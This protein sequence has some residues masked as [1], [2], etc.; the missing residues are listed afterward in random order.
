MAGPRRIPFIEGTWK[1]RTRLFRPDRFLVKLEDGVQ[2]SAVPELLGV[3]L[4]SVGGKHIPFRSKHVAVIQLQPDAEVL[5]RIDALKGNQALADDIEWAEPDFRVRS[6][7]GAA[8]MPNDPL[9]TDPGDGS[10]WQWG[11]EPM[12]MAEA[13]ARQRGSGSVI[14]VIVDNGFETGHPDLTSGRFLFG[15][16]FL[17]IENATGTFTPDGIF[18]EVMPADMQDLQGHGVGMAGVIAADCDNGTTVAGVNWA[19]PIG[20]CCSM[21]DGD[22]YE[23]GVAGSTST[24][25]A[26]VLQAIAYAKV[27]GLHLVV[28]L[29]LEFTDDQLSAKFASLEI[30]TFRYMCEQA[31]D[32]GALLVCAGGNNGKTALVSPAAYASEAEFQGTVLAVGFTCLPDHDPGKPV[33]PSGEYVSSRSHQG[34]TVVA[35]GY[36]WPLLRLGGADPQADWG[37]SISAAHVSGLASLIWSHR[38]DLAA[39]DVIE[40]IKDT[41]ELP[42]DP[43]VLL[44]GA[45]RINAY[46]ALRA[47]EKRPVISLV[48]DTSGSMAGSSGTPGV[49]RMQVLQGAADILLHVTEGDSHV[50]IVQFSSDAV[51]VVAAT[52]IDPTNPAATQDT[53]SARVA[54]L[55][56][57]GATSI[58]A[59]V[60]AGVAQAQG[61]AEASVTGEASRAVILM[62]DGR[63]NAGPRVHPGPGDSAVDLAAL[64]ATGIPVYSVGTG[65][66]SAVDVDA[67]KTLAEETGG[68]Y[69][70]TGPWN[71]DSEQTMAKFFCQVLAETAGYAS[72]LDPSGVL[73]KAGGEEVV[74][75]G[76]TRDEQRIEVILMKPA[77]VPMRLTLEAPDGQEIDASSAVP[78]GGVEYRVS[79]RVIVMRVMLP[80]VASGGESTHAGK[81]RAAFHVTDG[82]ENREIPYTLIVNARSRLSMEA[83]VRQDDRR[84]GATA[85]VIATLLRDGKPFAVRNLDAN[86]T[87]R[88][89]DGSHAN[90]KLEGA[91]GKLAGKV[92]LPLE[93]AYRLALRVAGEVDGRPFVRE[94]VLTA[95]TWTQTE[96]P[97]DGKV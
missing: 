95:A 63:E 41:A 42:A 19:S 25:L 61:V 16:S 90:A 57:S 82:P 54:A 67:L 4:E 31:R 51:E 70:V 33:L 69:A 71:A 30:E 97:G 86:L 76:V 77:G 36:D 46:E 44:W 58:G 21:D 8:P 24:V 18:T 22:R 40:V 12:G 14:A 62:T 96:D 81:W 56:S 94:K 83:R 75:F 48:A 66:T 2:G 7:V 3:V 43:D 74:D 55:T 68:E 17:Y 60:L 11:M 34:V 59:G 93:G 10:V 15:G 80:C 5:S 65:D 64:A 91:R 20:I 26:G 1:G 53:L 28:N 72:L 39:K 23:D 27:E 37:S 6:L 38:P 50:G 47:V 89:P 29:S 79:D 49:T 9:L 85:N 88:Q 32:A 78:I 84:P 35:P 45:G 13:W 92:R 52:E 87:I 73:T